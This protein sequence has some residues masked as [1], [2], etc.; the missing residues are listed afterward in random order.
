MSEIKSSEIVSASFECLIM[1]LHLSIVNLIFCE[2]QGIFRCFAPEMP[3]ILP[4]FE[5]YISLDTS[6][7]ADD[8]LL[9]I[10]ELAFPAHSSSLTSLAASSS[11]AVSNANAASSSALASGSRFQVILLGVDEI[12]IAVRSRVNQS[13]WQDQRRMPLAAFHRVALCHQSLAVDVTQRSYC[14]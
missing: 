9:Y 5:H 10:A 2:L 8:C 4:V 1:Y 12:Q 11:S 6:I 7:T 3:C 14:L 13:D